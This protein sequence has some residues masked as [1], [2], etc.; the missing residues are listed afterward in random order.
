MKEYNNI[1]DHPLFKK[2]LN[3]PHN[4]DEKIDENEN[5]KLQMM[6]LLII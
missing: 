3:D 4:K 2:F 6:F 1:N 5:K